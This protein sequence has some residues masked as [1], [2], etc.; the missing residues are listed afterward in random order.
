VPYRLNTQTD[1]NPAFQVPSPIREVDYSRVR[2]QS[3]MLNRL[4]PTDTLII[5][6]TRDHLSFRFIGIPYANPFA[7]FWYST[8]YIPISPVIINGLAFGSRCVQ[9]NAGSKDRLFL[10][11]FTPFLPEST[12]GKKL[13][14]SFPGYSYTEAKG[15]QGSDGIYDGG[16]MA[17][18]SDVVVV[19]INY[20]CVFPFNL[21]TQ[22]LIILYFS[23]GTLGFLAL[24]DG[25]TNGN[26]GIADQITALQWVKKHIADFGGDPSRVTIYG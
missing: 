20:R 13:K 14:Q 3:F 6:S 21:D 10:N 9:G 19:T 24:D 15:G 7:R 5:F 23:H 1:P 18:R 25:V 26:F 16:N 22:L 12:K 8:L 17:S 2:L 11:I 4:L